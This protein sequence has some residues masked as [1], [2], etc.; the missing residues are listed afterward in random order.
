MNIQVIDIKQNPRFEPCFERYRHFI[1]KKYKNDKKIENYKTKYFNL[2]DVL[3]LFLFFDKIKNSIAGF[4]SVFTPNIWPKNIA[5]ISNRFWIDPKYRLKGL[6]LKDETRNLRLGSHWGVTLAYKDQIS[7]C[8]RNNID[9][10]VISREN[11]KGIYKDN[12]LPLLYKRLKIIKPAWKLAHE[13]YLTCSNK[14]DYRCWQRLIY[15]KIIKN[16]SSDS[17]NKIPTLSLQEYNEK[18]RTNTFTK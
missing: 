5:R 8:I 4:V 16:K 3:G 2:D 7:C 6:S 10:A 1:L 18:F 9:I 11:V 13:Y 14:K 17:L 15:L 12:D